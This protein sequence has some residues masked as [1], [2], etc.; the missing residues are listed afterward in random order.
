MTTGDVPPEG[1]SEVP[2]E[3]NLDVHP[4]DQGEVQPKGKSRLDRP[5]VYGILSIAISAAIGVFDLWLLGFFREPHGLSDE[6]ITRVLCW[7]PFL[8]GAVA[9]VGLTL[10]VLAWRG[11]SKAPPWI[12]VLC[13]V[14]ALLIGMAFLGYLVGWI[15]FLAW[16]RMSL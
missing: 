1:S 5:T 14:G 8:V 11:R 15:F 12:G 9:G 4:V 3:G 16:D 2:A 6:S 13:V 10:V 7:G